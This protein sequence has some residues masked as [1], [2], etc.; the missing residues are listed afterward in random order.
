MSQMTDKSALAVIQKNDLSNQNSTTLTDDSYLVEKLSNKVRIMY[1]KNRNE[2]C[3]LVTD[4]SQTIPKGAQSFTFAECRVF[5]PNY[6]SKL[7][8][9]VPEVF[10][11]APVKSV[12]PIVVNNS[13]AT[14]KDRPM[15]KEAIEA[16]L[17]DEVEA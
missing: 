8:I 5:K 17:A 2:R 10:L 11:S 4:E 13:F 16:Y 1:R 9:M 14:F 6:E 15:T 7:D 3:T 12:F